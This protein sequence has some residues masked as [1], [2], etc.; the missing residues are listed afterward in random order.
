MSDDAARLTAA[1]PSAEERRDELS[2]R[3]TR[4]A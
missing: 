2:L 4:L 1:T 3:P